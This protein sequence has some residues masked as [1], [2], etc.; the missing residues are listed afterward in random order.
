MSQFYHSIAVASIIFFFFSKQKVANTP[1]YS[2][3]NTKKGKGD[4][5]KMTQKQVC[6]RENHRTASQCLVIYPLQA[7]S[8]QCGRGL[9]LRI[10][11]THC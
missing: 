8:I 2:R 10:R 11:N 7:G 5:L 9:S 1:G 3:A 6:M 4:R